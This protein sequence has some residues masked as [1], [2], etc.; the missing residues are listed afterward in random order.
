MDSHDIFLRYAYVDNEPVPPTPEGW[1]DY[2]VRILEVRL[3]QK[4]RRR[5]RFTLWSDKERVAGTS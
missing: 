4:L 2:F 3:A 1:V 5:G